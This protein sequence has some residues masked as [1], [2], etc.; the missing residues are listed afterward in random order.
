MQYI[1]L[2]H[3]ISHHQLKFLQAISFKNTIK[4][5]KETYG[6]ALRE[7]TFKIRWVAISFTSCVLVILVKKNRQKIKTLN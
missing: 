2:Q 3:T 6:I 7:V 5:N 1:E 4:Q